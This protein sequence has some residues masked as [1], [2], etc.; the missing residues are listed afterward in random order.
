MPF[1]AV[2]RSAYIGGMIDSTRVNGRSTRR[3]WTCAESA[4]AALHDS[5]GVP[6]Y[7]PATPSCVTTRLRQVTGRST[8]AAARSMTART[9]VYPDPMISRLVSRAPSQCVKSMMSCPAIPGQ[10]YLVPP[11]NPTTSCGNTGP[12]ITSSVVVQDQTIERD[13]HVAREQPAREARD[14]GAAD[15]ADRNERGRI[16]PAVIEHA[17]AAGVSSVHRPAEERRELCVRHRLV[18]AEGDQ[19][20]ERSRMGPDALAEHVGHE[21]HG[22]RARAVG[23]DDEHAAAVHSR[24]W[25]RRLDDPRIASRD[26][27]WVGEP[28]PT[29]M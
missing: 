26:R 21:R 11:E 5:C 9:G 4:A 10:K 12:Q 22:H 2:H 16:V 17:R 25:K 13:G 7:S 3:M 6:A 29:T 19:I 14:L 28:S 24:E 20:V 18:R 1:A 23:D 27:R 8:N 15:R